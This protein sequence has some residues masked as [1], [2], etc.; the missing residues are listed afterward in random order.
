MWPVF[1]SLGACRIFHISK[2]MKFHNYAGGIFSPIALGNYWAPLISKFMSFSLEK[3]PPPLHVLCS[4]FLSGTFIVGLLDLLDS[5]SNFLLFVLFSTLSFLLYFLGVS[6][7][8]YP[9]LLFL[10]DMFPISKDYFCFQT[11]LFIAS[12]S[13]FME[14]IFSLRILM[15]GFLLT[16]QSFL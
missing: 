2:V 10:F 12:C 3:C 16:A 9:T 4:L 14:G 6:S 5:S 15:S 1:F 7:T 13:S 11:L 8:F